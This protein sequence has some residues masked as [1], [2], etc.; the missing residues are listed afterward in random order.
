MR[1][2]GLPNVPRGHVLWPDNRPLPARWTL[3]PFGDLATAVSRRIVVEDDSQYSIL[4]MRWY[5]KGAYVKERKPGSRIKADYL[6]SV[7]AGD[8]IYNRLFAWKGSFGVI[9]DDCAEGVVSGEFPCYTTTRSEDAYF[10]WMVFSQPWIWQ[11][12]EQRSDGSTSTSRLRLRE[13]RLEALYIPL[14]PEE[15]RTVMVSMLREK[16]RIV[17]DGILAAREQIAALEAV[18]AAFIRE[19][20][21][22]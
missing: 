22:G 17:N 4:G 12:L 13:S 2:D 9:E 10:L 15:E 14:P 7:A 6:Y 19:A 11:R 3:R 8:F 21:N 18:S 1:E 16:R 20:I 5:A